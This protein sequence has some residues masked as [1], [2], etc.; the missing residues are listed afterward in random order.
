M[1]VTVELPR[2]LVILQL[3]EE[4]GRSRPL[5]S[6]LISKWSADL[7]FPPYQ[8]GFSLQQ[9]EALRFVNHHYAAGGSRPELLQK[10]KEIRYARHYASH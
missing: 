7:G 6:S 9:V 3:T 5:H 4:R 1:N 10:L 8:R 2:R